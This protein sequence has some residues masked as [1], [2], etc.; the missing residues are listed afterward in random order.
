M[1]DVT[2]EDVKFYIISSTII[3]TLILIGA[4]LESTFLFRTGLGL[5]LIVPLLRVTYKKYTASKGSSSED[6]RRIQFIGETAMGVLFLLGLSASSAG[7]VKFSFLS[8]VV[9]SLAEGIIKK[10]E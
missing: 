6:I 4:A 5:V 8:L 2:N 9:S 7:L 10:Y 1:K 3:T